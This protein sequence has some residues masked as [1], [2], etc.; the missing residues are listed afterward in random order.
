MTNSSQRPLPDNTQQS[1]QTSMP[2]VGLEPTI[3]AGERQQ[4][5]AS[6]RRQHNEMTNSKI[7]PNPQTNPYTL[8]PCHKERRRNFGTNV[9]VILVTRRDLSQNFSACLSINSHYQNRPEPGALHSAAVLCVLRLSEWRI[10][11]RIPKA[12]AIKQCSVSDSTNSKWR[13]TSTKCTDFSKHF[14]ISPI[15]FLGTPNSVRMP[16]NTPVTLC[17]VSHLEHFCK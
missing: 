8:E 2:P 17:C 4:T 3:S 11:N 14:L 13:Q 12:M 15:S 6:D 16:Y 10:T 1:R 9:S 7:P 5:Y